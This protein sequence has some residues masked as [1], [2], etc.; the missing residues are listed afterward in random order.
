MSHRCFF[1]SP[2]RMAPAAAVLGFALGGSACFFTSVTDTSAPACRASSPD[3]RL[4]YAY[5]SDPGANKT[6]TIS[7][8]K[9]DVTVER[10]E[11]GRYCVEL[12]TVAYQSFEPKQVAMDNRFELVT[13]AGVSASFGLESLGAERVGSCHGSSGSDG[14][15][16]WHRRGCLDETPADIEATHSLAVRMNPGMMSPRELARWDFSGAQIEKNPLHDTP[17]CGPI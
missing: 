17:T 6:C 15:W 1:P 7:P 10:D 12:H 8:P 9:R 5:P 16:I 3:A 2:N 14:I 4:S 13:D 11:T